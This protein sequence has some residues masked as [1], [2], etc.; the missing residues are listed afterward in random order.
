[1][2]TGTG[3]PPSQYE[4]LSISNMID[5]L[6]LACHN[7]LQKFLINEVATNMLYFDIIVIQTSY[8]WVEIL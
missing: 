5:I 3:L 2:F 6:N 1:M 7:D 4:V 8:S